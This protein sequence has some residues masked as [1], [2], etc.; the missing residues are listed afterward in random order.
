MLGLVIT[1]RKRVRHAEPPMV[2]LVRAAET[3]FAARGIDAV[4]MREIA[5]AARCGDTNAVTYY[6][7]SKDG[8][9]AAVFGARV[10]QMDPVRGRMLEQAPKRA[11]VRR[12][13]CRP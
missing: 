4:S 8:L 3:L 7:G 10:E 1:A 12:L 5:T 9:L 11:A 2:R 6:F 13:A